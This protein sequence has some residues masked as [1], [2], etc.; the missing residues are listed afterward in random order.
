MDLPIQAP[1]AKVF[2]AVSTA[3]GLDAWWTRRSAGKPKLGEVYQLWF[4]PGYDWRAKV[5]RCE[6]GVEF[7]LELTES[8]ADWLGTKVGV[9]LEAKGDRTWVRFRHSGWKTANEHYRITSNCWAM[10]LRIL[11]RYLE[12][13]EVVPYEDRLDV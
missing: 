1:A 13:G 10:Y 3:A 2:D 7:E 11:R 6:K 9:T 8:D 5:T 12:Q 4:G